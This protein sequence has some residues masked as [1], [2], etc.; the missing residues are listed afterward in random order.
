[1][2]EGAS[3]TTEPP[4]GLDPHVVRAVELIRLSLLER[5]DEAEA[6][7]SLVPE[8]E[9]Y[10]VAAA[11]VMVAATICEHVSDPATVAWFLSKWQEKNDA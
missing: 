1:M 8:A 3:N 10:A 7:L 9:V 4:L 11:A 2:T 6:L 5:Y